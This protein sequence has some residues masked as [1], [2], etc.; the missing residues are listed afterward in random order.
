MPR[1]FAVDNKSFSMAATVVIS[2]MVILL[3]ALTLSTRLQAQGPALTTINGTVYRA[4]GSGYRVGKPRRDT[5]VCECG[6]GDSRARRHG[7]AP[8]WNRNDQRR[9]TVCCAS[10]ASG[11]GGSQ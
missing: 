4:D 8:G 10:S 5:A 9:E 3:I 6:S 1:S 11:A 2:L 7:S